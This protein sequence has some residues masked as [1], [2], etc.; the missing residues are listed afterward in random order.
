MPPDPFETAPVETTPAD[1]FVA[2]PPPAIPGEP[3]LS[4]SALEPP[5]PALTPQPQPPAPVR[6]PFWGYSDL[7]LLLGFI[8]ASILTITILAAVAEGFSP[9]LRTDPTPLALPLQIIFYAAIYAGFLTI[10][11]LRY[12][13]DALPSLGWVPA[14][15]NPFFAAF[16]GVALAL[17]LSV[18][19]QILRTPETDFIGKLVHSW[20]SFILLALTAIFVAPFFEELLFRGFLQPLL[21]RTFGVVAGVLITAALFGGLHLFQYALAWQYALIIFLAGAT[22]GW[23]RART[24][25][26]VPGTVMHCC[27]NSVSLIGY[28]VSSHLK[29]K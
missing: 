25:S 6:H 13:R 24:G 20:L 19:G 18:L 28:V 3:L 2:E 15:F 4:A 26:I 12:N 27:F 1:E 16:V 23:A 22:F 17:A 21:S 5:Q 9:R 10:F 11:K 14:R 7:L 8:A 29:F